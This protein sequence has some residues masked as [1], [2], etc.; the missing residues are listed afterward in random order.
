[1]RDVMCRKVGRWMEAAELSGYNFLP[2][3]LLLREGRAS[4][5]WRAARQHR[6]RQPRPGAA[7]WS[8]PMR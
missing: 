4:A 2:T 3:L 1:M 8:V 7:P 5:R 6:A